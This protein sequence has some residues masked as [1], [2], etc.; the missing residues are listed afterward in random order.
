MGEI[1]RSEILSSASARN[2]K[3]TRP[4]ETNYINV[5]RSSFKRALIFPPIELSEGADE[6]S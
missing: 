5:S 2:S 4:Y 3:K 6:F 1:F